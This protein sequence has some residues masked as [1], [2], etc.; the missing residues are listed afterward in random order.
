MRGPLEGGEDEETGPLPLVGG[1]IART[2]NTIAISANAP[3][4]H[5]TLESTPLACSG[6]GV[7]VRGGYRSLLLALVRLLAAC[8]TAW[9]KAPAL[10]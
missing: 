5:S 2:M 10:G 4:I 1:N 3:P 6:R 8:A 9:A 7:G